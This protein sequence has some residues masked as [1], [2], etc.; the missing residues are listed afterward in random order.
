MEIFLARFLSA[1]SL[2]AAAFL[3]VT[4]IC[5]A[6]SIKNDG[7]PTADVL[8]YSAQ[9]YLTLLLY[10]LPFVAY[11]S[12]ISSLVSSTLAAL[13]LGM[14]GYAAIWF[15]NLFTY[16]TEQKDIFTY[17]LAN[18]VKEY[19]FELDSSDFFMALAIL[20]IYTLVY[21]GLAFRIFNRR[22]L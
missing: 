22:N 6:L 20:P 11:M 10:A 12:V 3:I 9:V 15:L 18:G 17:L 13:F 2:I 1:F 8:L 19:L 5:A 14:F 16:F 7:Y 21:A 4:G